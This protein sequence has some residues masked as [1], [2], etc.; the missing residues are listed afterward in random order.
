MAALYLK[1][2]L[3]ATI[4]Q[5]A[6]RILDQLFWSLPLKPRVLQAILSPLPCPGACS[7]TGKLVNYDLKKGVSHGATDHRPLE[8]AGS[9]AISL[10]ACA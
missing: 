10:G 7:R 8:A 2:R 3:N 6:L 5:L 4:L 1:G 9:L